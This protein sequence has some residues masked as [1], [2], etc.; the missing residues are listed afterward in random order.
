MKLNP[1]LTLFTKIKTNQRLKYKKRTIKFIEENKGVGLCD[2]GF[3][4][5]VLKILSKCDTKSTNNKDFPG[6]PVGM[7]LC[8]QCRGPEFN[9]WLGN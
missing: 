1:Y 3:G 2:T 6:G 4:N 5:G 9:P 8:S 7:T